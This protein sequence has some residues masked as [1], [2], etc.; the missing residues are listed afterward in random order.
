M[1]PTPLL[2]AVVMV[3]IWVPSGVPGSEGVDGEDGVWGTVMPLPQPKFAVEQT[4]QS[5]SSFGKD[6]LRPGI[7]KQKSMARPAPATTFQRPNAVSRLA[8]AAA[9]GAVLVIVMVVEPPLATETGLKEQLIS[10]FAGGVQAKVTVP[11]N[12]LRGPTC[13]TT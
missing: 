9:T 12:P 3:K 4:T 1:V 2:L 5:S 11:V 10:L 8:S 6:L 13:I 7:A